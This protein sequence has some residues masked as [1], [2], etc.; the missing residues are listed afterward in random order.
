MK[1]RLI[2]NKNIKKAYTQELETKDLDLNLESQ[3]ES[4]DKLPKEMFQILGEVISF[5]EITNKFE[6]DKNENK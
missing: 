2:L 4:I 3:A 1:K 6:G 5:I